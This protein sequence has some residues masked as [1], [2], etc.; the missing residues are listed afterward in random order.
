MPWLAN[1]LFA[2]T[3]AEQTSPAGIPWYLNL[4][5]F[6]AMVFASFLLGGYLGKKLRMPDHGWKIGLILFSFLASAAV[7]TVGPKWHLGIDLSGGAYLVYQVDPAQ[8]MPGK[9]VDMDELIRAVK[10]RVDPSGV[11]EINII[12]Y[13]NEQIEV[14]IPEVEEEEVERIKS[15]I[16]TTGNLQFRI[17]ANTRRHKD[18]VERARSDAEQMKYLDASGNL[19]AWWVPVKEGEVSSVLD[20][21]NIAVR[22]R[23]AGKREVIEVLVVADPYNITGAYLT[24]ASAGADDKGRDA[25]NFVFDSDGG[26][27]FG[28]LTGEYQPEKDGF[29]HRLA[30]ILDDVLYSAPGLEDRIYNRGIIRGNFTKEEVNNLVNVLKAG[31]L[32]AALAK[33]PISELYSGPSLGQDM[34]K[35]GTRAMII[36]SILIPLFMLWY[37]RFC[38]I[39]ADFALLLNMMMLLALMLIFK[40]N[41]TLTGFA[42]LALTVGMAV[43]NNV[44]VYERLREELARGAALRMAIRNAFQRASTTIVD[45]NLTT[46]IAAAVL[47]VFGREQ[48]K[49]FAVPLFIGVTLSMY[50]SIFVARAILDVAEKRRWITHVKM[51]SMVGHTNFDF[52]RWFPLAATVSVLFVVM[53][54]AVSFQRGKDLFDIDFTG[55][56]SV[57]MAFDRPED[58]KYVRDELRGRLP[59]L[60][61]N[62]VKQEKDELGGLGFLVKTSEM[63]IKKVKHEL[64]E[65]FG[66]KL[67]RNALAFTA[68][69]TIPTADAEPAAPG[70]KPADNAEQPSPA[71]KKTKPDPFAGGQRT[72]LTFKS[73]I[74]HLAVRQGLEAAME[75]A[76]LSPD[77]VIYNISNDT[78]QE[79]ENQKYDQWRL[80]IMLPPQRVE[81]LLEG[82]KAH[83]AETP[84]FPSSN[85]IGEAVASGTQTLAISTLTL[86]WVCI[87]IFLWI[88]F[89]G[90]SFGLAAVAALVHDV[91]IMLGAVAISAYLADYLGFLMIDQFKINLPIVAA[92][93]TI[94]GFSVNDTIVIFDRIRE[95]RGKDPNLTREMV[96]LSTNQTLS[97]T[98]LTSFTVLLVVVILYIFGGEAIH[99]FAFTLIVGTVTG[100]YSSVYVASPILLWMVSKKGPVAGKKRKKSDDLRHTNMPSKRM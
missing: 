89:Q 79:G 73:P 95:V 77:D 33:E 28:E 52:L 63:S 68:P 34:I 91:F 10:R 21:K 67:T 14:T 55:G 2:Q 24:N 39:V 41:F 58:I 82:M 87:I 31:S 37:Y 42:G 26:D 16:T 12:K 50:T 81:S 83:L 93:L 80:K 15:L 22:K 65:A 97:R 36:A 88:R 96:N 43:D 71:E 47:Y 5:A 32:P 46:L 59:D 78:Y 76:G 6:L 54:V 18:L 3:V 66:E 84:V 8:K 25:V 19:A 27:L 4:L 9:S 29:T 90:V 75:Q 13:G 49:G 99:G 64:A 72:E 85:E 51:H 40:A 94:I 100:T 70:K 23:K 38:G 20:D 44:L 98:L 86:S 74:N 45:A 48:L 17:L 30:I 57:Q 60:A 69:E 53:A 1:P 35:K 61:V 62:S 56:V 92:F 11:K 7:L